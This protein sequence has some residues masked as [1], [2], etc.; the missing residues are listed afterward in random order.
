MTWLGEEENWGSSTS[1]AIPM[2]QEESEQTEELEG[3]GW[4]DGTIL[5][6]GR[7]AHCLLKAHQR[8]RLR[9]KEIVF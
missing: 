6:E 9:G 3:K 1:V 5:R 8:W 2:A 7:K 4:K